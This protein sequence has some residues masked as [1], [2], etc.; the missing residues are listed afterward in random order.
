M[1]SINKG[2]GEDFDAVLKYQKLLEEKKRR[3]ELFEHDV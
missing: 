2:S 3:N 1:K